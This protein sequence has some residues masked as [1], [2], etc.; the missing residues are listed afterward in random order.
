MVGELA[1]GEGTTAKVEERTVLAV[2]ILDPFLLYSLRAYTGTVV[3]RHYFAEV[4][5]SDPPDI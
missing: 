1:V 4:L 5:S 2:D 3:A